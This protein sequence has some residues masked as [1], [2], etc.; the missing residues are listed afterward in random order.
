MARKVG[1]A[2]GSLQTMV[3]GW[4]AGEKILIFYFKNLCFCGPK[5]IAD[6]YLTE[7]LALLSFPMWINIAV[8]KVNYF[9][10]V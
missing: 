5:E 10:Q 8:N 1:P 9:N 2:A 7:V 6:A 4:V 3:V